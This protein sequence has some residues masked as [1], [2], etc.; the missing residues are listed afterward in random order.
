MAQSRQDNVISQWHRLIESMQASPM[1]FYQSLE[2]A[3][4]RRQ[5]PAL[6]SSKVTY[7]EGNLLT[8]QR[9]YLRII[10]G[11]HAFDICAAPFGTGFFFSWRLTIRRP[12]LFAVIGFFF[13]LFL[14]TSLVF[15]MG[16]TIA[17]QLGGTISSMLIGAFASLLGTLMIISL[18]AQG[19]EADALDIGG[20]MGALPLVGP[21]YERIFSPDTYYKIDTILMFQEAVHNA[22]LEVVDGMTAAQ[23]LRA[24]TEL[25]RKPVLK[26][27]AQTA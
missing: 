24:L 17:L 7:Y 23:G 9:V 25:E 22:V 19:V 8:A 18:I 26:T 12:S 5:V 2:T 16:M 10:R 13:G 15:Q 6:N 14:L 27:F 4:M 1:A 11:R 20:L 21:L 3:L